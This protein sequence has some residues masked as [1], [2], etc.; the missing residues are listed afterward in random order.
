M[1]LNE[2]FANI[3]KDDNT[4]EVVLKDEL[5]AYQYAI[6]S[7]IQIALTVCSMLLCLGMTAGITF[8]TYKTNNPLYV[9]LYLIPALV[10]V[11]G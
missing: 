7:R 8:L 2:K 9:F 1:T 4:D 3:E 5:E 11:F 6:Y 10:Y